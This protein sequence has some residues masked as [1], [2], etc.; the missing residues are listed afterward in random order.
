MELPEKMSLESLDIA[1]EKRERLKELL[2]AAFPEANT[3]DKIDVDQ[4]KRV[5][6]E[7][8]E[9]PGAE[10]FGLT[11]PGKAECM[12]VIQQPSIATLKPLRDQSLH[13]DDTE[14][15]FIEGDNL[16][17][18]KLLQKSYFGK[19]KMIYIDPPYNTGKEFIYPDNYSE[20]LETYLEYT[21]QKDGEGRKFSTNTE[22]SGRYHSNWLKMMYPR[23]YLAKNLLRD[24]GVIFISIDDNEQANLKALCDLIFGE[25]NFVGVFPWR[26]RTAKADVPYGVSKDVEWVVSYCKQ[27]FIAGRIGTRKYYKSDDYEDAWRLQDLTKNTTKDERPNSYFVMVNPKNGDKYPASKIRTWS[28]TYETFKHY[29]DKGKIVFPGDYEFLKIKKPAFRVFESED[30]EKALKNYGSEDIKMSVSTYLPDKN[31][32]RTEHGSKEI[33]ALFDSQIF[34]YPK[35]TGLIKFFIDNI[36][37]PDAIVMD[38]FAGSGTT[39]DALMQSNAQDGGNRKFILVQLPENLDPDSKEQKTAAEY[40]KDNG[41][42]LNIAAL[43]KERIRRA[44][45]KIAEETAK[46]SNDLLNLNG[47][48]PLDLGFKVFKLAP[49]NFKIWNGYATHPHD[50]NWKEYTQAEKEAIE[51]ELITRLEDHIDH[52]DKTASPEDILYE[53]LL[54]SGFPLTTAIERRQMPGGTAYFI[55][56]GAMIICLEKKLTLELIDAIAQERPFYVICLDE[57]F[58]GNDQLKVN[59]VHSFKSGLH[60]PTQGQETIFRTV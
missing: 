17:V 44:A 50:K 22:Q 29:Y 41:I 21:G 18:L 48:T 57:G 53:L 30:K 26:S 14:N 25:E 3:E 7:W 42:P 58:Q 34:S 54:K 8:A 51:N 46:K 19:V 20:T 59:A 6:G 31:V 15:L 1:G 56:D 55:E 35:P 27:D 23:L 12:R 37:D 33:R 39:A 40:C 60:A 36:S 47:G 13:F 5:L 38:F 9:P 49:S 16:E 11:W 4:L 52:I 45:E 43:C 32:G 24:D 10:R 28:V 2:R